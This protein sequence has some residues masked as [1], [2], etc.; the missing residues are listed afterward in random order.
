MADALP[1]VLARMRALG[2]H[3]CDSGAY[4]LNLFGIRSP[5]RRANAFDDLLGCAYREREDSGWVVRFWPATTDPGSPYLRD[6]MNRA[7]TAILAAGQYRG[8]Y[9]IGKH[10]GEYDA[11]V[12]SGPVKVYRDDNR[13][14]LLDFDGDPV[15]GVFGINLHA[16]A[17]NPH[18]D[19][20]STQVGKWSAGCQVHATQ[21][22]FDEMMVLARKQQEYHPGWL[23]YSYTLLDQW[24]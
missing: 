23:T 12:Q 18:G 15:E 10:R 2:L 6:P 20:R 22:G 5:E 3:V 14:D 16:S 21:R 19:A 4:D 9:R 13:D 11:L 1:P 24:W 8:A 17:Q 7:G